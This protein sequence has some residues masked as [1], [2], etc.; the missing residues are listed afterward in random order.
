MELI[1]SPIISN[2][3]TKYIE[4]ECRCPPHTAQ[5]PADGHCYNI[6]TVG[7]CE[8]GQYFA[9]D[10]TITQNSQRQGKC[11]PTEKCENS[12]ELY[13]PEDKKCYL[14]LSQ[15]PCPKGQLITADFDGISACK[16]DYKYEM[17]NYSSHGN[18][19]YEHFTKGPCKE[20]GHLFLPNQ[21]CGCHNL[22]PHYYNLTKMCYELGT[23]GPCD[24]GEQFLIDYN[25]KSATCQCKKGHIRY[26]NDYNCYR[27]YTQG[28]CPAGYILVNTTSCIK[29]PCK[30]GYLYFV[31]SKTCYRIGNRGPCK[32]NYV[33]SFDFHTRPSIDGIS[34]N[35]V[36]R[37]KHANGNICEQL[38]QTACSR[39]HNTVM[40]NNRCFKLYSQTPCP[41]GAWLVIKRQ[42]KG[43]ENSKRNEGVCECMP[44]YKQNAAT[45]NDGGDIDCA[46][47][48]IALA[49]FLNH[50]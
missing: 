20:N 17:R 19:C 7:P 3:T 35:A 24:A 50:N 16:C 10:D 23:I 41:T 13:W 22:L 21:H 43:W 49:E 33:I 40:Y 37:C 38:Q 14:Y 2:S 34:Y 11:K 45:S 32:K 30:R 47:P 29:Q 18:G 4:A 31:V 25:T 15:G 8:R 28:P 36:C 9:P 5:F 6:F 42:S 44:G 1:P 12:N 48:T 46:G 39:D 27:P 26:E